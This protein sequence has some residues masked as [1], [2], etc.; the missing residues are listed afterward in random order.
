[1]TWRDHYKVHPAADVFPMMSDEDIAKLGADIKANGLK[2]PIRFYLDGKNRVLIDG[3]NRLEAM[4]RAGVEPREWEVVCAGAAPFDAVRWIVSLNIHRR[5]L[6]KEQ[7]ADM[8]VATEKNRITADPVSTKGGRGKKNPL[9]TAVVDKA[10]KL[11]I[12]E[13]TVKRSI[14]KAEGK[15]PTPTTMARRRPP[16]NVS[17]KPP[18]EAARA[19]YLLKVEERTDIPPLEYNGEPEDWNFSLD[20]EL[21][22]ITE[23]F[24]EIAGRRMKARD[25]DQRAPR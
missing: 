8:I 10:K 7:I 16:L 22:L 23:A 24:R 18:L 13:A 20:E 2:V 21:R 14:A 4:E 17:I 3:R 12:S 15:A 6:T 25:D 11:D 9:K 19:R 1:M 5:H